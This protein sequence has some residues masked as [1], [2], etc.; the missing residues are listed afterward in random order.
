MLSPEFARRSAFLDERRWIE[1]GRSL[2]R[3]AERPHCHAFLV[4]G[5]AEDEGIMS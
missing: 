1:L 2:R 4:R 3:A 5:V